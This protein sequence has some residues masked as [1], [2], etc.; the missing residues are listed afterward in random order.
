[1]LPTRRTHRNAELSAEQRLSVEGRLLAALQQPAAGLV[2]VITTGISAPN[3]NSC[4][5]IRRRCMHLDERPRA[6]RDAHL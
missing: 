3:L 6:D 1:M 2:I 5:K 4:K